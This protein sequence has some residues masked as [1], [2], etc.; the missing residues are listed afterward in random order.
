[1]VPPFP[2]TYVHLELMSVTLFGYRVFAEIIKLRILKRDHPGYRV[3]EGRGG[4]E[5][6]LH[7]EEVHVK[8][9]AII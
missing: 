8:M 9:L 7:R 5:A 6:Q 1:M 2:Q 3:S 4:F